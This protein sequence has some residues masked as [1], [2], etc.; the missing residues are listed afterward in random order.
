L[1]FKCTTKEGLPEKVTFKQIPVGSKGYIM[2]TA[3]K[4]HLGRGTN[5]KAGS[6]CCQ[7]TSRKQGCMQSKGKEEKQAQQME[8][9]KQIR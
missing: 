9:G 7:R 8:S 6:D 4:G 3:R 5:T 2:Q 1:I